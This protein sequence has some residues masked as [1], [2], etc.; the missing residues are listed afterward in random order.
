M[1]CHYS[2]L[3]SAYDWLKRIFNLSDVLPKS[4]QC[5]VISI[6]FLR[7][8]FLRFIWETVDRVAKCRLSSKATRAAA[9]KT[10]C[11]LNDQFSF[12]FF[13]LIFCLSFSFT[14]CFFF[15]VIEWKSQV[16]QVRRIFL[17]LCS[18]GNSCLHYIV[19]M[20]NSKSP[21]FWPLGLGQT[22]NCS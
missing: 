20:D 21:S 8:S 9:K 13:P 4:G 3:G 17:I 11:I 2:D 15:H 18:S 14:F 19:T 7:R 22:S 1:T 12:P 6:E 16:L 10:T 5:H